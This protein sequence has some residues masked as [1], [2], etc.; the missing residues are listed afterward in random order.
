MTRRMLCRLIPV[1]RQWLEKENGDL[2]RSDTLQGLAQHSARANQKPQPPVR[3]S[4]DA[5]SWL[6]RTMDISSNSQAVSLTFKAEQGQLASLVL[7]AEPLRQWLNILHSI[8]VKAEW[9]GDVW[10]D[11]IH[12]VPQIAQESVVVH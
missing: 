10:P 3:V 8:W 12:E 7:T 1:L 6:V 9:S 4:T 5:E 11:W 2:L